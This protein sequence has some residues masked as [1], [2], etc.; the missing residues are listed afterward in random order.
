VTPTGAAFVAAL[1]RFERP[2]LWMTAAGYGFGQKRLPWANCLRLMLGEAATSPSHEQ[3]RVPGASEEFERDTVTVI[4]SNIDT[5]TGEALGWLLERLMDA[6]ALDVSYAPL[7]MKKSR[8]AVL[9][10]VLARL[11]DADRLAGVIIRESATLGVRMHRADRLKAGRRKE[12]IETPLG[13]ARVKLKLI[14]GRIIAASPEYE[15]C[16]A[17][18]EHAGL[19]IETVLRRVGEAARVHFGLDADV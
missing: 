19:P 4:E 1:A 6:G 7:Q 17:L 16:R 15:D 18:A 8:P 2:T 9:L 11:D 5:M 12:T 10:T 14:G 3:Q 13:P